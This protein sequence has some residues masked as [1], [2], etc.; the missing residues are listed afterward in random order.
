MPIPLYV[1]LD[2]T[3]VA[4]DTLW[5]SLMMLLKRQ[6]LKMFQIPIWL[7]KG[8]AYMKTQIASQI[9]LAVDILPYRE[10]VLRFVK[11][12]RAK[13]T[14]V[15]LA[16]AT[17]ASVAEAVAKYLDCFDAVIA[18]T[19][20]KNTIGRA[21]AE[22]IQDHAQG[23]FA[24][25]GDHRMDLAIWRV[26][27]ECLLAVRTSN[28]K[29]YLTR[30]LGKAF[31]QYFE[32]DKK[33]SS[34]FTVARALRLHQWSK[35]LLL[36]VPAILAHRWHEAFIWQRTVIAFITFGL[37]ASSIY[38]LND[39]LDLSADR[40]HP[41]KRF[42]PF[43]A[44]ALSIPVGLS[45]AI[46]CLLLAII[47]SVWGVSPTFALMVGGY[48]C[49]TLVYSL[50][51]KRMPIVDVL[52]L[53]FFYVYRLIAGA[54]AT[55][56]TVTPWLLAFAAFFFVGLGCLKRVGELTLWRDANKGML[57][58]VNGRGY[59]IDDLLMLALF[60]VNAGFLSLLVLALYINSLEVASLYHHPTLLWGVVAVL[61][62]WL[63]RVW[64][65]TWRGEM[66]DDPV[67]FAMQDTASRIVG[68]LA[69]LSL[70]LAL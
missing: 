23:P 67:S 60:G 21:K 2:G 39:L 31:T 27:K 56:I 38:V 68:V 70:I 54:V 19:L 62:Y 69:C 36:F 10:E 15:V 9:D 14:K 5:E 46:V 28:Q 25:I 52:A 12:E 13:G 1:D 47:G 51:L 48:V 20:E 24:Y 58:P 32:A 59:V 3:L 7:L 64:F 4:T 18:T 11:S 6:P 65:L 44:G 22:A 49:A 33:E 26:A 41:R 63:M 53:A 8:K 35:N 61:L 42:R 45:L 30:K 43:A 34:L 50:W 66:H 16:T 40:R 55:G 37:A 29:Q 57:T 17:P